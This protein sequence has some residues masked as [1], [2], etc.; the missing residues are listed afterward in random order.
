M[1]LLIVEF[2]VQVYK[3]HKNEEMSQKVFLMFEKVFQ[4]HLMRG[5]KEYARHLLLTLDF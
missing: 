3:I 5:L 4:V 2:S 1:V